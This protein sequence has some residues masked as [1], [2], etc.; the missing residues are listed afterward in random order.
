MPTSATHPT[1]LWNETP[2]HGSEIKTRLKDAKRFTCM[3]A[4]AKESGFS[5]FD[6]DLRSRID[7]GMSAV[8][9]IG[10]D[11]YQSEPTVIEK[12]L[13]LKTRGDVE[14]YMGN[15]ERQFT[16]HQKLYLFEDSNGASAIVGSAN[17]TNGG[18]AANHELSVA[19][20]SG[21]KDLG[22]QIEG[23]I[24]DLVEDREIVEA[25]DE[26]VEEYAR[27]HA[28]YSRHIAMAR[29]RAERAAVSPNGGFE[30]LA[31]ILLEM[32]AD[33]SEEGFASSV[34]RRVNHR[35][36][37]LEILNWRRQGSPPRVR[38]PCSGTSA[39]RFWINEQE[40][41]TDQL[42]ASIF[43]GIDDCPGL[44]KYVLKI[45]A[46]PAIQFIDALSISENFSPFTCQVLTERLL[47][48]PS[49]ISV[50]DRGDPVKFRNQRC[51]Q[52]QGYL[53]FF[54]RQHGR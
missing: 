38:Q 1:L 44:L 31:K 20:E 3:V 29:R 30:T 35:T 7:K 47:H 19:F 5:L 37:G 27:R 24:N 14:V 33:A 51:R 10:I 32:K 4:F 46:F 9:V 36:E 49:T 2:D 6:A 39:P 26:I 40:A 18:L 11:F 25:T 22:K 50:Q 42:T 15:F 23:W 17:M 53:S 8:F 41:S 12:L 34:D 13:K 21:A 16:F 43:G 45:D 54:G 28:I 52:P 48:H